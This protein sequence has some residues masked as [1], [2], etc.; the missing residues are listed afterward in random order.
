MKKLLALLILILLLISCAGNSSNVKNQQNTNNFNAEVETEIDE[1]QAVLNLYKEPNVDYGEYEFKMQ[2][3]QFSN[4]SWGSTDVIA[5]E[6]S[7]D[8]VN[9]AIYRRNLEVEVALN[10]KFTPVWVDHGAQFNSLGTSV[11]AGDGAFDVVFTSFQ[12]GFAMAKA[13]Y[14]T[15]LA[16]MSS[17][18]ITMPWWDQNLIKETSVLNKVH[19]MTGDIVTVD[20]RGMWSMM[21]NKDLHAQYNMPDMYEIVK[22]GE[23][24]MDKLAEFCKDVYIDLNGN[25]T[26]DKEDQAAIATTYDCIRSFFFATGSRIIKKDADDVPFFA[27]E[28]EQA[29]TNLEKIYNL[30]RG[31]DNIVMFANEHGDWSTTRDAF[32]EN[33]AL[34]YMEVMNYVQ[35]LRNMDTDFGV[36]P[37]PKANELQDK[38][39]TNIHFWASEA[40]MVPIGPDDKAV[41][42]AGIVLEAMG[43][44][45][46]KH[47]RPAFYEVSIKTKFARDDDSSYMIDLILLGRSADLGY[48]GGM[49]GMLESLVSNI[50]KR[51]NAFSSTIEANSPK[52]Y[53]EIENLIEIYEELP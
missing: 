19:Y 47:I 18:D 46:F 7:G 37:L 39:Y 2:L 10:I 48:V 29:I 9:D 30:F 23:W 50:S 5:E 26:F 53:A 15:D 17:I 8:I 45:G 36:I 52:V 44:G 20:K 3:R 11:M 24:T 1:R 41:E 25:G 27:L 49:G 22:K 12:I 33:R 28:S 13:G 42:R 6:E 32:L 40:V 31:T 4:D 16:T 14:L 34:F 21:F 35:N 51:N 38:Y 43:Y